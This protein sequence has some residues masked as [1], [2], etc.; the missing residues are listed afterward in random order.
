MQRPHSARPS[1]QR[2]GVARSPGRCRRRFWQPPPLHVGPACKPLKSSLIHLPLPK[3][4]HFSLLF[5]RAVLLP[6]AA[7][8]RPYPSELPPSRPSPRPRSAVSSAPLSSLAPLSSRLPS[9]LG[10]RGLELGPVPMVRG[11]SSA[12]AQS[13][14]ARGAAL[15]RSSA[16]A[17]PRRTHPGSV[18]PALARPLPLRARLTAAPP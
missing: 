7:R 9:R 11:R 10:A 5:P 16:P 8:S 6:A 1:H 18:S 2:V 15:P 13:P 17:S 4:A 3:D 14:P 12:G